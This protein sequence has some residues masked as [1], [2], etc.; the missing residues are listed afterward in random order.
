MII[1]D[2]VTTFFGY[3]PGKHWG[4]YPTHKVFSIDGETYYCYDE[5]INLSNA[6]RIQIESVMETMVKTNI[7]RETMSAVALKM[8]EQSDL[9]YSMIATHM[10]KCAK[11][12]KEAIVNP[13]AAMQVMQ[14]AQ[15]LK[16]AL[17]MLSNIRDIHREI[18]KRSKMLTL[19][20]IIYK[21]AALVYFT[22]KDNPRKML[23][24]PEIE[25]RVELFKKKD[26][27]KEILESPMSS[28]FIALQPSMKD[29]LAYLELRMRESQIIADLQEKA[30]LAGL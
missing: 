4:D 14:D 20:N 29:S 11:G 25:K 28:L 8:Y 6:R 22:K 9:A 15:S 7:S 19:P 1:T 21:I 26:V 18:G 24:E 23:P 10:A 30:F 3:R 5:M 12:M 2:W 13:G 16:E 17:T 27:L